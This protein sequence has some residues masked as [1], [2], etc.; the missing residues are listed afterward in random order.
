MRRIALAPAILTAALLAVAALGIGTPELPGG[1]G[2]AQA[3]SGQL[4]PKDG[5][6]R[7]KAAGERHWHID[8]SATRGG[9]CVKRDGVTFH[10]QEVEVAADPPWVAC[11][12]TW[13][14]L[15]DEVGGYWAP[16]ISDAARDLLACLSRAYKPRE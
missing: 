4:S 6:H 16:S 13:A 15:T 5:C 14:T 7:D 1:A 8:G 11:S 10:V 9:E 3:H 12:G 2:E